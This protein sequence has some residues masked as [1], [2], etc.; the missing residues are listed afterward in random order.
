M[1][2]DIRKVSDGTSAAGKYLRN[3]LIPYFG[4]DCVWEWR[5]I[6]QTV[7]IFSCCTNCSSPVCQLNFPGELRFRSQHQLVLSVNV[8]V[9][10]PYAGDLIT[11]LQRIKKQMV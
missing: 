6:P 10:V 3:F 9:P 4:S 8:R 11:F 7:R 1:M 2:S 5:N